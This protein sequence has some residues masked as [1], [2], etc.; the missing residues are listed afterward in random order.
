VVDVVVLVGRLLDGLA[1][2]L[3]AGVIDRF[4]GIVVDEV[5]AAVAQGQRS[6]VGPCSQSV[7]SSE[8]IYVNREY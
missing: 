5:V 3:N 6:F 2:G 4:A 7:A 8:A 1:Q